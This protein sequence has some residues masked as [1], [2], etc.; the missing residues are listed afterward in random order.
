MSKRQRT[1]IDGIT[2]PDDVVIEH[3]RRKRE[4]PRYD[5]PCIQP[6]VED[7]DYERRRQWEE[8]QRKQPPKS[9]RGVYEISICGDDD[10]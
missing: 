3:E 4:Q 7:I 1:V 10:E 5:R 8:Q 9:D 6:T 2:L